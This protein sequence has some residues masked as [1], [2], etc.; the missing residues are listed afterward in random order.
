MPYERYKEGK[1]DCA[2]E[3][4][5]TELEMFEKGLTMS[6]KDERRKIEQLSGR[7]LHAKNLSSV[8]RFCSKLLL[9]LSTLP[10]KLLRP[11]HPAKS[12]H[13]HATDNDLKRVG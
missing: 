9:L 12:L 13:A 1:A 11:T 8:L 2:A 4:L 7:Y 10:S 5:V 3:I 6:A